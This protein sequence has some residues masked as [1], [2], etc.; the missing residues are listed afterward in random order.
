MDSEKKL[1][2]PPFDEHGYAMWEADAPEHGKKQTPRWWIVPAGL[3][4]VAVVAAI[5]VWSLRPKYT[6]EELCMHAIAD[7][8]FDT[9]G[10]E[11]PL[12]KELGLSDA[13][14][15]I[16][17]GRYEGEIQLNYR[18]SNIDIADT[19]AGKWLSNKGIPTDISILSGFGVS[20]DFSAWDDI[21]FGRLRLSYGG[22]KL[23][24]LEGYAAQGDVYVASPKL[25]TKVLKVDTERLPQEWE[26]M[27]LW[28][29]LS[30]EQQTNG[31]A[32]VSDLL[33]GANDLKGQLTD[34]EGV[35]Y[36]AFDTTGAFLDDILS[37]YTYEVA[38]DE[39]G[40]ALTK[41]FPVGSKKEACQGYVV[42]GDGK[43]LGELLC[44]AFGLEAESIVISG[45]DAG[46]MEAMVYLTKDAELVFLETTISVRIGKNVYAFDIEVQCS[47]DEDPQH[48]A[49]MCIGVSGDGVVLEL[50]LKK[51]TKVSRET[52]NSRI[53]GE[54]VVGAEE[55]AESYGIVLTTEYS[56]MTGG[57]SIEANTYW[58]EE[59]VGAFE[60]YGTLVWEEGGLVLELGK[61]TFRN[62]FNGEELVLGLKVALRPLTEAP[63][64]PQDT[65]DVLSMSE[66][67]AR[68]L[69]EELYSN[70][71]WYLNL[72]KGWM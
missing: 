1:T 37:C 69:W 8:F 34:A 49:E 2:R 15:M 35:F 21:S 68:S 48:N 13:A 30:E 23:S 39:N 66:E 31:K 26:S 40:K 59:T 65:V 10:Y 58:D 32:L 46:Q 7:A 64:L 60:T 44:R 11:E 27:A 50:T 6:P 38:V 72:V 33:A 70:L 17:G 45:T 55:E 67:D 71:K 56:R 9:F 54:L 18:D 20:T 25:L 24:V 52:V 43:A 28:S 22:I 16:S 14:D 61:M 42:R 53:S 29:L 62:T 36:A 47:G 57:L 19:S 5:L 12:V 51:N 4:V 3:L 63:R 41:K